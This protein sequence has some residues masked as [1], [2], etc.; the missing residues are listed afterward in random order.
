[1]SSRA[2]R[3]LEKPGTVAIYAFS[4]LAAPPSIE[5]IAIEN[6]FREAQRAMIAEL[7]GY[8]LWLADFLPQLA[9]RIAQIIRRDVTPGFIVAELIAYLNEHKIIRPGYTTLQTLIGD[10]PREGAPA[11]EPRGIHSR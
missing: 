2:H 3:V 9:Q 1:M 5:K 7:F 6:G 8:R 10:A 4:K 11:A